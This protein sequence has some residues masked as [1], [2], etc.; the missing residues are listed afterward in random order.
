MELPS[1]LLS[2]VEQKV[3][4]KVPENSPFAEEQFSITVKGKQHPIQVTEGTGTFLFR[5]EG[6]S[7]LKI[8]TPAGILEK[9][10]S[11]IPLWF[12]ILPPLLAI[13]M[14]LLFREVISSLLLGIFLGTAII[15]YY[16]H[17]WTGIFNG[18]FAIIDDYILVSLNDPG[19][20]SVIL[21]SM[22]IGGV[23]ALISRNGGMKGV[24]DH[25]SGLARS[26]KSGQLATWGLGI[27]IFFD[28]YANTLVV[29]N[30]MRPITDRLKISRE[31]LAYLVDSTAA[32]IAAVAFITTWIGAELGYIQDGLDMINRNDTQIHNSVYSI[33]MN[34]LRFSFYP[35]LTLVFI[36][37]LVLKGR[38]FGPM[39][40]AE[41][42]ARLSDEITSSESEPPG[43]QD[44][45]MKALEPVAGIRGSWWNAAIPIAVIIF[46]TLT[47]LFYTGKEACLEALP[48][49]T[50]HSDSFA[51]VWNHLHLLPG[52]PETPLA[53]LGTLIGRSDSYSALLWSSLAGIFIA[54]LLTIG[55]RIMA[56][57]DAVESL[58][59]GFKTMLG[60]MIILILAWSLAKV[61][62]DLHTADFLTNIMGDNIAPWAIPALTF[63]L[64]ALIAFSTGSSWGTMAILY[65]L[66]L[67]AAWKI[68][69]MNGYAPEEALPIF[70]NTVSCVLAGS[71]LGDHCSPI[72]DTTILSS[73]ASSCDHVD[74]VRT[75]LPYALTVGGVALLIGT[76]PGA[77]GAAS[78]ITYPLGIAILFGIIMLFGK[79]TEQQEA[80]E[81]DE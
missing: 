29:G 53:K 18:L 56:L 64:A 65:P 27:G 4:L 57:S 2:H 76:I 44:K 55:Q 81:F 14:A 5:P 38:D 74:H 36:L 13:F 22:M 3:T 35:V 25:I 8:E 34:S 20:L 47:G 61:T 31:K 30:T 78:W 21:F 72:S 43:S 28:D 60:T 19:H 26:P 41:R 23:V 70:Y 66:M 11:P 75:Q 17:G 15:G 39:L 24:V 49:G 77:L 59:T 45:E 51:T 62:E 37:M 7:T 71:V 52:S 58:L 68:S 46:G 9:P 42:N 6:E 50:L 1:P 63:L 79:K 69:Q 40:K 10:I 33:F 48:E 80:L 67:P 54:M 16:T 12:S 73:L 32:P